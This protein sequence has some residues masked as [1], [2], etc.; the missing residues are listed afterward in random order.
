M[1]GRIYDPLLGR[2]LSADKLVQNPYSLQNYNR[3]AYVMNNPLTLIDPTGYAWWNPF[4]WFNND[5]G[6]D[7]EGN[8]DDNS[9]NPNP[10]V[11]LPNGNTAQKGTDGSLTIT[12]PD[13]TS[14]T[15][16]PEV[17]SQIAQELAEAETFKTEQAEEEGVKKINVIKTNTEVHGLTQQQQKDLKKW[18]GFLFLKKGSKTLRNTYN[19]IQRDKYKRE[20]GFYLY[21]NDETLKLTF[22]QVLI[23]DK[24]TPNQIRMVVPTADAAL[25]LA[26]GS[27]HSRLNIHFHPSDGGGGY[28]LVFSPDDVVR[29]C[30]FTVTGRSY[31]SVMI[32]SNGDVFYWTSL[33]TSMRMN[34]IDGQLGDQLQHI[35]NQQ[36]YLGNIFDEPKD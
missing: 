26:A 5:S 30:T 1:N 25:P 15:Y 14:T 8:V 29:D 23:A 16:T 27:Y 21:E 12:R 18:K 19:K 20:R 13:G 17:L 10:I 32:N 28:G 31:G 33:S 34:L 22:G 35:A 6:D 9:I 4:S 7:N 36:I 2:F 24:E 3:Y 11:N